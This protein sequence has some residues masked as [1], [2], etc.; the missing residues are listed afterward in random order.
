MHLYNKVTGLNEISFTVPASVNGTSVELDMY[1]LRG[2]LVRT[3]FH[4]TRNSGTFVAPTDN[5]RADTYIF[6]LSANSSV[7]TTRA[8]IVK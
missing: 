1:D 2:A 6:R 8:L 4:G 3:I 7:Q 5:I